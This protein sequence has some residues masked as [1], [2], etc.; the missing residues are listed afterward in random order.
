MC[1]KKPP[2][3]TS[4]SPSGKVGGNPYYHQMGRGRECKE[5]CA[6]EFL[7]PKGE[8]KYRKYL[9]FKTQDGKM[10]HFPMCEKLVKNKLLTFQSGLL[11]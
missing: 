2:L 4:E 1:E 11:N 6:T 9:N 7:R 3:A 5:N 10:M 8:K